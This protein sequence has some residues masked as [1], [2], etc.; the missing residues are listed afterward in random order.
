MQ[1]T[2]LLSPAQV[3]AQVANALP[4]DLRTNVIIIGSLAAGYYFFSDDGAK[5][6]RTKD[7]DCLLSPYAKAVTAAAEVAI[8]LRKAKWTQRIDGDWGE[9]GTADIATKDLPMVRLKPPTGEDWF[10]ELLSAPPA[11]TPGQ[12]AKKLERVHTEEGDYAIC[13]FDFL[14]LVEHAPIDTKQKVK[15]ARPEMMALANMLHHPFIR[16]D[17]IKATREKR[18]N[19]DLGRV[20]A[21]AHLTIMR[22]RENGV[23]E[24]GQWP[25]TMWNALQEKFGVHAAGLAKT[26]GTGI[27][28]LLSSADD[29][30][31]ALANANKGLLASLDIG[32]EAI[33]ATGMRLQAEV[34]EVLAE[35]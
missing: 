31:Q 26:A 23:D 12:E 19:K 27:A 18:S 1:N 8:E 3:L 33:T 2:D 35:N 6:I 13:S 21:L 17:E 22:D 29:L 30:K 34:I 10:L 5:A 20:L 9:P 28:E 15:I 16:P 11:Y 25:V 32:I 24:F 7:V 14:A 4:I